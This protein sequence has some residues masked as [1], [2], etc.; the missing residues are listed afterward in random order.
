MKAVPVTTS[1][2]AP[3]SRSRL[4]QAACRSK[5][6]IGRRAEREMASRRF[7]DERPAS[8]RRRGERLFGEHV[9]A[10][11]QSRHRDVEMRV[12]HRQVEHD[13]DVARPE[14]G[15]HREGAKTVFRG[16]RGRQ[17]GC[18]VGTGPQFDAAEQRRVSHV[19]HRDVAAADD[20]DA[21]LA[22]GAVSSPARSGAVQRFASRASGRCPC[23]ERLSA[24]TCCFMLDVRASTRCPAPIRGPAR[25]ASEGE[26]R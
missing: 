25:P 16:P 17:R 21:E 9:L 5:E 10:G 14:Q 1:P 20:A 2:I 23:T 8:L 15:F 6:R 19:G 11:R 24:S 22:H 7:D 4:A 18:E 12:R 13:V 3:S 26:N